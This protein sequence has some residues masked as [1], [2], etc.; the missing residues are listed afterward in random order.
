MRFMMLVKHVENSGTPPKEFMDAMAKLSEE[1]AK[2]GT[3]LGSG[4]LAPTAQST[5]VRVSKGR[6]TVTDGPFTEAKEV[7]GGFAILEAPS[8]EAVIEYAKEFL[9]FTGQ[10]ECELRQ[11]Y[12]ASSM[13]SCFGAEAE[14]VSLRK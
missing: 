10:G 7:V 1:A 11:L 4:G 13:D 8:K 3:M 5:R 14:A 2:A 6:L 9:E 12:D